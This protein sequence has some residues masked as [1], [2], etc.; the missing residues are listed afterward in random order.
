MDEK[1]IAPIKIFSVL[2]EG[3]KLPEYKTAGAS[4]ADVFAFLPE[5][6]VLKPFQ[7]ALI[8]TGVSVQIPEGYELQL[9]PRSGLALK[10]G[11]TVLNTPG[12]ID[13]DYRGELCA[14]LVNFGDADFTVQNGERI[15]QVVLARVARAAFQATE[16]LDST[17]RGSGGY[18]STGM[19]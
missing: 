8:P 7:R 3:A 16:S 12:T 1:S 10:H 15:A 11:I 9:R 18:G 2:K 14:L 17:A 19:V 5:P 4:G 6:I 13:S